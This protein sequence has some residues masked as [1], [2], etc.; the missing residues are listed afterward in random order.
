MAIC[1]LIYELKKPENEHRVPCPARAGGSGSG[2][3]TN[4]LLLHHSGGVVF[5]LYNHI[6]YMVN[7][8]T[9]YLLFLFRRVHFTV[10]GIYIP[11][12][13]WY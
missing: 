5:S 12:M 8:Y 6:I 11:A 1:N 13:F 3:G 7:F 4:F 9:Y 10:S 2:S